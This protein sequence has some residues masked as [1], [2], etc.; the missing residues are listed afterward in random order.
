M[1]T[2]VTTLPTF[3]LPCLTETLLFLFSLT[4]DLCLFPDR[5]LCFYTWCALQ[6]VWQEEHLLPSTQ[7][8]YFSLEPQ[9]RSFLV[10][11]RGRPLALGSTIRPAMNANELLVAVLGGHSS[12]FERGHLDVAFPST[13]RY[14]RLPAH[15][16]V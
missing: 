10:C 9:V 7:R 11:T 14:E 6:S 15:A 1:S 5:C 12:V 3:L 16:M 2:T 4:Q 13:A 8:P